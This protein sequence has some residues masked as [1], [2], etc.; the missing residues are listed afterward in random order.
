MGQAV[1]S[2]SGQT[3]AAQYFGPVFERQVCRDH[4]AVAL[5]CT[6]TQASYERRLKQFETDSQLLVELQKSFGRVLKTDSPK[7][8]LSNPPQP[9]SST[10]KKA[11]KKKKA[12]KRNAARKES[13]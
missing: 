5:V 12:A 3:L 2:G 8:R 6:K 13:I 1:E 4:D 11:A 9:A 7:S 10:R